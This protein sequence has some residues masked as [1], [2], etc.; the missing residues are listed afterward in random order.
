MSFSLPYLSAGFVL[1]RV[2]SIAPAVVRVRYTH[3]P[4]LVNPAD[5]NDGLNPLNYQLTGPNIVVV[6]GVNPVVGDPQAVD[7]YA[8]APLMPGL[9]TM[10]VSPAVQ[11]LDLTFIGNPNSLA[12]GVSALASISPINGGAV[13][14]TADSIIRKHLPSSVFLGKGWDALIAALSGGDDQNWINALSAFDQMF[15]SSAS[16]IYLDRLAGDGGTSR[17]LN[18][19]MSDD[20]FRELAIT[21]ASGKLTQ[22]VILKILEVFYGT[23]A[24]KAHLQTGLSAPF[25][26][27]D[28]HTLKIRVNNSQDLEIVFVSEDFAQ[29]GQATAVEV[30]T[31]IT[32]QLQNAGI[33]AFAIPFSDPETNTDKVK[34][35][36]DAL[37]LI[38]DIVILGGLAQN[39]L[40]FPTLLDILLASGD[41]ISVEVP[42][43]GKARY[44]IETSVDPTPLLSVQIGDYVNIV[45]QAVATVNRGSFRIEDVFVEW[46]GATWDQWFEVLNENAVAES[47]PLALIE[48]FDLLFYRPKS[49]IQQD[50]AGRQVIASQSEPNELDVILPATTQAVSRGPL[51]AAYANLRPSLT[52]S[53]FAL[54][55]DGLAIVDTSASH[56]L[57]VGNQIFL[58]GLT[59]TVAVAAT[60]AGVPSISGSPGTTSVCQTSLWSAIRSVDTL[61]ARYNHTATTLQ[62][63]KIFIVG[64]Y[65]GGYLSTASRFS[66]VSEA[67]LLSGVGRGRTQHTYNYVAT[68]S[69]PVA[70][71]SHAATLLSGALSGLVLVTGGLDGGGALPD[72][73]LYNPSLNSWASVPIGTLVAR[74]GHT[75]TAVTTTLGDTAVYLVGGLTAP[76]VATGSIQKFTSAGGGTIAAHSVETVGRYAHSAVALE[77]SKFL[78]AGGAQFPGPE[79]R[80]D[81]WA[82][83]ELLASTITVGNLCVARMDFA[84]VKIKTGVALAIGGY[85]RNTIKESTNRVLHEIELFDIASKRWRPVAR[86]K[87]ARRYPQASVIGNKVYVYSG[88]D[89]SNAIVQTTEMYDIETGRMSL[90]PTTATKDLHYLGASAVTDDILFSFGGR[91]FAGTSFID[92]SVFVP[93]S[94]S[95]SMTGYNAPASVSSI[96]SPTSFA[97]SMPENGYALAPSGSVVLAGAVGSLPGNPGP[98]IWDPADGSSITATATASNQVLGKGQQ[99]T[100]LLVADAS[101]F[102]DENGYI[103]IGFG[104]DDFVSPVKYLG[105]IS[106]NELRLDYSFKFPINVPLGASVTL[107]TQ[108]GP[109]VPDSPEEAGSYYVTGSALGRVAAQAAIDDAVA[110]GVNVDVTVIYPGDNGLGGSGLPAEGVQKLSDKVYVWAGD[111]PDAELETAREG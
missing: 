95:V 72:S 94:N 79:V 9:W 41:T 93:G 92:T 13:Q 66:I 75:S 98:Y 97:I 38:S 10:V 83:D 33:K 77:D 37:G 56:G 80:S 8:N 27:E 2:T 45:S 57:A 51:S 91:D 54:G 90:L 7:V 20:L 42:G 16:G 14:D 81:C 109:F 52:I 86:L 71:S 26:I 30:A 104:T 4:K 102:P 47:G 12:F 105:K 1:Q 63:G 5:S 60:Q 24:V 100:T 89:A 99:Y 69:R 58:E 108:R 103:A 74:Y 65:D 22:E 61:T 36:S 85:G 6:T 70:A 67:T 101:S 49:G 34:I 84:L 50:I 73:H 53:S 82:Y 23:D 59:P 15:V 43:A 55:A 88:L 11:Q 29:I 25:D 46:N 48:D 107:L 35:Y 32:R 64:G 62:D 17:P 111:E 44:A 78:V 3:D 76:A 18:L 68:A 21:L 39:S 96:I 106:N 40:Q 110:G 31:V 28:E 19:G 87:T